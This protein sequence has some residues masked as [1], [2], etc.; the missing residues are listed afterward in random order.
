MAFWDTIV[1]RFLGG[2]G[3]DEGSSDSNYDIDYDQLDRND[4][5]NPYLNPQEGA[6]K[7]QAY[8]DAYNSYQQQKNAQNEYS[9]WD[10]DPVTSSNFDSARRN[11]EQAEQD[12]RSYVNNPLIPDKA[13]SYNPTYL[14][15]DDSSTSYDARAAAQAAADFANS[16]GYLRT[17][18]LKTYR[19]EESNWQDSKYLKPETPDPNRPYE[20]NYLYATPN[21]L[22][23][24]DQND[25]WNPF[26]SYSGETAYFKGNQ[27]T[28][29]DPYTAELEKANENAYYNP[30]VKSPLAE[31]GE[32]AVSVAKGF[33]SFLGSLNRPE[34]DEETAAAKRAME[35]AFDAKNRATDPSQEEALR[36]DYEAKA[37][38]Y[39]SLKDQQKEKEKEAVLAAE[40]G[41]L[42]NNPALEAIYDSMPKWRQALRRIELASEG[43]LQ[44]GALATLVYTPVT[45]ATEALKVFAGDIPTALDL[46]VAH[47]YIYQVANGVANPVRHGVGVESLTEA[48]WDALPDNAKRT[49]KEIYEVDSLEDFNKILDETNDLLG[50]NAYYKEGMSNIRDDVIF[51]EKIKAWH[52]YSERMVSEA[53]YDLGEFWQF[54]V[55]LIPSTINVAVDAV[56][57]QWSGMNHAGLQLMFDRVF[58]ETYAN[59]R[60]AGQDHAH[61]AAH[62]LASATVEVVSELVGGESVLDTLAYG[63]KGVFGAGI[64]A[65]ISKLDSETLQVIAKYASGM[66]SEALEEEFSEVVSPFVD[67]IISDSDYIQAVI[68]NYGE[69]RAKDYLYAALGAVLMTGFSNATT[70]LVT[71]GYNLAKS[72]V[73]EE[74]KNSLPNIDG[75]TNAENPNGRK[76]VT[77]TEQQVA[78][79]NLKA[80]MENNPLA[81][82]VY[83][84][85]RKA[86]YTESEAFQLARSANE[87]TADLSTEEKQNYAENPSKLDA[88]SRAFND[89][90]G[91][92]FDA[93]VGSVVLDADN[94]PVGRVTKADNNGLTIELTNEAGDKTTA[95]VK[96]VGNN[97]LLDSESDL[98]KVLDNDGAIVSE[99]DAED[100]A[101]TKANQQSVAAPHRQPTPVKAQPTVA[102]EPEATVPA[103]RPVPQPA[104]VQSTQQQPEANISAPHK[105][106]QPVKAQPKTASEALT[107]AS[108]PTDTTAP[109]S[110]AEQ[111]FADNPRKSVYESHYKEAGV[112]IKK[113]GDGTYTVSMASPRKNGN[114]WTKSVSV[115]GTVNS[116]AEANQLV[117]DEYSKKTA[118][119]AL[120]DVATGTP[121]VASENAPEASVSA[122][123]ETGESIPETV[124]E[125]SET[126][127]GE[128]NTGSEENTA[129]ATDENVEINPYQ[130]DDGSL[131]A[132]AA[133][134]A[135]VVKGLSQ[136]ELTE[137][138][139]AYGEHRNDGKYSA[140]RDAINRELRNRSKNKGSGSE[141]EVKTKAQKPLSQDDELALLE[142]GSTEN[143]R[144]Q[145]P[146]TTTTVGN[147][148]YVTDSDTNAVSNLTNS[149]EVYDL[150]EDRL[151]ADDVAE[152]SGG[153]VLN[154]LKAWARSFKLSGLKNF[155]TN[156]A[157]AIAGNR[158]YQGKNSQ[159]EKSFSDIYDSNGKV[160]NDFGNKTNLDRAVYEE[161][162]TKEGL[163][164]ERAN[165]AYMYLQNQD[166]NAPLQDVVS[167]LL[168]SQEE[169]KR[170]AAQFIFERIFRNS[171]LDVKTA[172]V[173]EALR[174][175]APVTVEQALDSEESS[176]STE[177][178]EEITALLE[179]A[180]DIEVRFGSGKYTPLIDVL[181]GTAQ[182]TSSN[183]S[184]FSE[185]DFHGETVY[186]ERIAA[187]EE[188]VTDL[189]NEIDDLQK[190]GN[191]GEENRQRLSDIQNQVDNL[192]EEVRRLQTSEEEIE[193]LSDQS[194]RNP[195]EETDYESVLDEDD[196]RDA[197]AARE[198]SNKPEKG[199]I[200][201]DNASFIAEKDVPP[202]HRSNDATGNFKY[203]RGINVDGETYYAL[204]SEKNGAYRHIMPDSMIARAKNI[205]SRLRTAIEQKTRAI[206]HYQAIGDGNLTEGQTQALEKAFLDRLDLQDKLDKITNGRYTFY[207]LWNDKS[208]PAD[209]RKAIA[210]EGQ[211]AN[212]N[213]QS[214]ADAVSESD[215][216][217]GINALK[218]ANNGQSSTEAVG[219]NKSG[220]RNQSESGRRNALVP[221][222]ASPK[223]GF[224]I[225]RESQAN[226]QTERTERTN[227]LVNGRGAETLG[228]GAQASNAD[229][230]GY[231]QNMRDQ[232]G[233]QNNVGISGS[234]SNAQSTGDTNGGRETQTVL[235]D[236]QDSYA[237]A[238]AGINQKTADK[239]KLRNANENFVKGLVNKGYTVTQHR[240]GKTIVVT[241]GQRLVGQY[242]SDQTR[243]TERLNSRL[244]NNPNFTAYATSKIGLIE[245]DAFGNTTIEMKAGLLVRNRTTGEVTLYA[246]DVDTAN[247]ELN[248][249]DFALANDSVDERIFAGENID[250]VDTQI[251]V[252]LQQAL[253][254]IG[255]DYPTLSQYIQ[256]LN[257][258]ADQVD[259]E[260]FAELT[261]MM[262]DGSKSEWDGTISISD[263]AHQLMNNDTFRNLVDTL[264]GYA[265]ENTSNN[266][267]NTT[268]KAKQDLGSS[269][270]SPATDEAFEA[271]IA[272]ENARA[273]A[274][275]GEGTPI[276]QTDI[277]SIVNEASQAEQDLLESGTGN[278][279]PEDT[280]R[281]GNL[282]DQA[283][284]S[285]E[286][287][288]ND[289]K[290]GSTDVTSEGS[291]DNLVETE[292]QSVEDVLNAA[293]ESAETHYPER[294]FKG[295]KEYYGTAYE[296]VVEK[297]TNKR[298]RS[299]PRSAFSNENM[300]GRLFGKS[301][302]ANRNFARLQKLNSNIDSLLA[303][304]MSMQAFNGFIKNLSDSQGIAQILND[305]IQ[306]EFSQAAA[307]EEE[308]T[309]A[310]AREGAVRDFQYAAADAVAH[311]VARMDMVEKTE[312][313]RV[314]LDNLARD[315][316]KKGRQGAVGKALDFYNRMQITGDNFWRMM[317]N[318]DAQ[319]GNEGYALSREHSKTIATR[320]SEEAKLK[321][322]FNSIDKN[323]KE[324]RDFANGTTMS[325]VDFDG[326]KIS[327]MEGLK[328]VK[329][330]DT[331]RV[332][333]NENS[334]PEWQRVA[335]LGGF[336]FKG[337]DGKTF[338]VDIQGSKK[339][340]SYERVQWVQEK[341]DQLKA[342]IES[343]KAAS[344]YK[345]ALEEMYW[346]AS[347]DAEKVHSRVNGYERY[348]YGKGNYTDIH[349]AN[350]NGTVDFSYK[351][352]DAIDVHDTGIM[353][354]RSRVNGGYV[355]V[356]PMSQS[357]DAYISQISNYIAFEEFGQKLGVL[358]D[359]KS[360][361]SSYTNTIRDAY[362][363]Q[364]AK[365]FENYVKSMTL[366]KETDPTKITDKALAQ[367][368][369]AMMSGALIGSVSV[370]IKQVSSYLDTMGMLD[371]RAV[372][373]AFRPLTK[374]NPKSIS[375]KGIFNPLVQSRT[376]SISDPDLASL[377]NSGLLGKFKDTKAGKLLY[378]ATTIM[379]SR[380]VA[381]VYRATILDVQFN[382]LPAEQLY[383]NGKN[384]DDG[385]TPE[386]QFYVDSKFEQVLLGTQPIF[387]PQ[388][389]NE[390][391][392]TDNQL[393]RMFSTFRTQQTQNY[394]RAMQAM[395]E[396]NAAKKNGRDTK[397]AGKKLRQTVEGQLLA[398]ASLAALTA[399][400]NGLLHKHH[401]YKD[402]DDEFDK[403]KFWKRYGLDAL[404]SFMG[405]ALWIGDLTKWAIDKADISDS[406]E[407]YGVSAGALS[408][409]WQIVTSATQLYGSIN[410][411]GWTQSNKVA[412]RYLAGNIATAM[413]KPVNN[414]YALVN[415]GW[416]WFADAFGIE[417]KY[418]DIFL[419]WAYVTD[420]P[421]NRLANAIIG[422]D[423]DKVKQFYDEM[424][425]DA[426]TNAVY[427]GAL[428]KYKNGKIDKA[429]YVEMLMDFAGKSYKEAL[430]EA[431]KKTAL[432]DSGISQ[433]N[434][435]DG[436]DGRAAFYD[437]YSDRFQSRNAYKTFF[438]DVKE[439][440]GDGKHNTYHTTYNGQKQEVTAN[441]SAIIDTLNKNIK[442]GNM[443][444]DTAKL[445]WEKYYGYS[446]SKYSAWQFVG[447]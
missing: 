86:G 356:N 378:G 42:Q 202:E 115:V 321:N 150:G 64:E 402:D 427:Y 243:R 408:T 334:R 411:D 374:M 445:L 27:E 124:Q 358:S 159:V 107:E 46:D 60:Y 190:L 137:A 35:E 281:F 31:F 128:L 425:E 386:G 191:L 53:G 28:P 387:T 355:I 351:D 255:V 151:S 441:Q 278:V 328:F 34:T 267:S 65:A 176:M 221:G 388:A 8:Q 40:K 72:A 9:G 367:A 346:D 23:D 12:W 299:K 311:L 85:A 70:D 326:H 109:S 313:T 33:N 420:Q 406:K 199:S 282:V 37:E 234:N 94:N 426:F 436:R 139:F 181:N 423:Y 331:L 279:S 315:N 395:N 99:A 200:K 317:G 167:K 303:G 222:R 179:R 36:K 401:K 302:D 314:K 135:E 117:V 144:S 106:P 138:F 271:L 239:T 316:G 172:T 227:P 270:L 275:L 113:N 446:T 182:L 38:A 397:A 187:I 123:P 96:F 152:M 7:Y 404:E 375:N 407:F 75:S 260:L 17:N 5:Y 206:R 376:Q 344:Q 226:S 266:V 220:N 125:S 253:S 306:K 71:G 11:Y 283:S 100:I 219:F 238:F 247:H 54:A 291:F 195:L 215:A 300:Y 442:A 212:Y 244:K 196:R 433:Y 268:V 447:K 252:G 340:N 245:T 207:N 416:Q 4:S 74:Y 440:K 342:E 43:G 391:A 171:G 225:S 235:K 157:Q 417:R 256:S 73:S 127:N 25:S 1:D 156:F 81:K 19:T 285:E 147:T 332:F 30:V 213:I 258:D 432:I 236:V 251:S 240:N 24:L 284:A 385:L 371:P 114:G 170:A 10:V 56:F 248:H 353:Q 384:F 118:P 444:Y 337:K 230:S 214:V 67:A 218:G 338:F 265:D 269:D 133:K 121:Y 277:D 13:P 288:L 2:S 80:N 161:S 63:N 192:E 345:A 429:E 233:W 335:S 399:I 405:N 349:Y 419:Q 174:A 262:Y 61:A 201:K 295:A 126:P 343:N 210:G 396:W 203:V 400:A 413:G 130:N 424:G 49:L 348:M 104:K 368:R 249:D 273:A 22:R 241:D 119:K 261:A 141:I 102:V 272:E 91:E 164:R 149:E 373:L 205:F 21:E 44:R 166:F 160:K 377:F 204:V 197:I 357:V 286:E 263:I 66:A 142:G 307:L 350:K 289:L 304:K 354:K 437:T 52:D 62:S 77:A 394:N 90:A 257:Y 380:T 379:D 177:D 162:Q 79:I 439:A 132:D 364:Y 173:E 169:Y 422:E 301:N 103:P 320:I 330:C 93:E 188:D 250:T 430:S 101:A 319:S 341:Y 186:G 89:H 322:Y 45:K 51:D 310:D 443:T 178:R 183:D 50:Q 92:F 20:A 185:G 231:T 264:R 146:E 140:A 163:N 129:P 389:R 421:Q 87:A 68:D 292:N 398:S 237:R 438:S 48:Q 148:D 393:M 412:A 131:I 434:G 318:W 229:A 98:A 29:A 116:I 198:R 381:N 3:S 329:I 224:G 327:L 55:N 189:N 359:G 180:N 274:A 134:V 39:Y 290:S 155:S 154:R 209:L 136:D 363:S 14:P 57:N 308:A 110:K 382:T 309:G 175:L 297:V 184:N 143:T 111:F 362:G 69:Q 242:S 435:I 352:R 232:N 254:E 145:K 298:N 383:K 194:V 276:D 95:E 392:R 418:D 88:D 165:S 26:F 414:A 287:T 325:N 122:S 18:D 360:I 82:S 193:N 223:G 83:E 58:G 339:N 370:P 333:A 293:A 84:Q 108:T 168:E 431:E 16:H 428:D 47:R 120:T 294:R 97:G 153:A 365:Y 112:K 158:D 296:N 76:A 246:N 15:S 259:E 410:E 361:N 390:L 323:S 6:K 41:E 208:I 409:A 366:Y 324:F 347:Q 228:T 216:I 217:R 32:K 105:A 336:A 78:N 305:D 403:E 369:R 211:F 372:T 415:A 280:G 59:D 312:R